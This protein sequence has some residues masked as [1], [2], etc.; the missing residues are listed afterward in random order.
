MPGP[1]HYPCPPMLRK[2][3]EPAQR[4]ITPP[5]GGASWNNLVFTEWE[6]D[7]ASFA[8]EHVHD[9]YVYVLEGQL[10][11]QCDGA[12]VL[13]SAGDVIRVPGGS[14]GVYRTAGFARLLSV[15]APNPTGTPVVNHSFVPY[16]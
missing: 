16:S 8:D 2:P 13:A 6:L 11:V 14:V 15:Y 3:D 9:E 1:V 4:V 5:D 10:E 12:S 7:A